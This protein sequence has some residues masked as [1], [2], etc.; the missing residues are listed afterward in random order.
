MC[1]TKIIRQDFKNHLAGSKVKS[2]LYHVTTQ[3]HPIQYSNVSTFYMLPFLRQDLKGQG[4]NSK[5]KSQI[6]VTPECYTPTPPT[7]IPTMYKLSIIYVFQDIART[8]F[9][10][11]KVTTEMSKIKSR[12]HYNIAHLQ[13]QTTSLP[14]VNFPHLVVSEIKPKQDF[15]GQGH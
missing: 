5:V 1:F 9:Q 12:S 2:R 3:Q 7:N 14:S 10:R 11:S 15:I 8:R 13:P 6:T 4:H